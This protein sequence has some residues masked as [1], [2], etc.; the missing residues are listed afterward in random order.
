[1]CKAICQ[2]GQPCPNKANP[3]FNN[4]Y[5]GIATHQKQRPMV[6][7]KLQKSQP[8]NSIWS[9]MI[10]SIVTALLVC[11]VGMNTSPQPIGLI[12]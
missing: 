7:V 11:W 1:M 2:K 12:E 6:S 9:H 5:C 4:G 10:S 3:K 8:M